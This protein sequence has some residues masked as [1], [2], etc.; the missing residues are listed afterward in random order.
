MI[1]PR[2]IDPWEVFLFGKKRQGKKNGKWT[3]YL[4]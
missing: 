1:I 2:K 3:N 4:N